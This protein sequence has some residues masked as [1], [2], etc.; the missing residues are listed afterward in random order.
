MTATFTINITTY[1]ENELSLL[2]FNTESLYLLRRNW[3]ALVE[4]LDEQFIYTPAQLQVLNDDVDEDLDTYR[5][6]T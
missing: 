4:A 3:P 5:G 2:V 6:G 1:T